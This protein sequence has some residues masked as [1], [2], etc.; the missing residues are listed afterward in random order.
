MSG[1]LRPLNVHHLDTSSRVISH[2]RN[3][4]P[5][6]H[7]SLVMPHCGLELDVS[8][9]MNDL[10]LNQWIITLHQAGSLNSCVFDHH[11]WYRHWSVRNGRAISVHQSNLARV[12]A[13]V[14]DGLIIVI[15]RFGL[16]THTLGRISRVLVLVRIPAVLIVAMNA[17]VYLHFELFMVRLF[18]VGQRFL[19]T[20]I[21]NSHF[22]WWLWFPHAQWFLLV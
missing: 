11:V 14:I 7:R 20:F 3:G 6:M 22:R 1:V 4:L 19:H 16:D 8:G 18:K 10:L 13:I 2:L 12:L 21:P 5:H 15:V 17:S 9:G